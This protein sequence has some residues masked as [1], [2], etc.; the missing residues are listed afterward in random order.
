VTLENIL[1]G[2]WSQAVGIFQQVA[3]TLARG[4]AK[5]EFEVE[6]LSVGLLSN[7]KISH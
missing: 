5:F 1:L 4:E 6:F 3:D 7:T 2:S